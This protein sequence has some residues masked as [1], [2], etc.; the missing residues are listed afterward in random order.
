I[1]DREVL[2]VEAEVAAEHAAALGLEADGA[3]GEIGPQA[4]VRRRELVEVANN[5]RVAVGAN[6]RG[7]AIRDAG[8]IVDAGAAHGARDD[9][10]KWTLAFAADDDVGGAV[11]VEDRRGDRADFRSAEDDQRSG[12]TRLH[13]ATH[14]GKRGDVPDVARE[15]EN[16]GLA[17]ED[18]FD[19]LL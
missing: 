11:R 1:P 4:Q 19:D 14:G 18:P 15:P 6:A 5:R 3:A 2:V 9:I 8:H 7:R 13:L 12:P 10:G 17:L 16:G